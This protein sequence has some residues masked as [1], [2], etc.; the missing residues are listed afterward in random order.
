MLSDKK[1]SKIEKVLGTEKIQVLNASHSDELE[2]FIVKS[3]SS[4]KQAEEELE[5]NPKFQE[6]KESLKVLS[7]GLREVKQFQNSVI[8][9]ALHLLEERGKQ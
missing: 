1:I 5:A 2:G 3:N 9:F 8:Q 7:S 6:L 4:I